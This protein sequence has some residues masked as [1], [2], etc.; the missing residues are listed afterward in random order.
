MKFVPYKDL[1]FETKLTPEQFRHKLAQYVGDKDKTF[2]TDSSDN[3]YN[4]EILDNKFKIIYTLHPSV[5]EGELLPL[6][7]GSLVKMRIRLT[8]MANTVGLTFTYV[9]FAFALVV[10]FGSFINSLRCGK[11]FSPRL[12]G[13]LLL[14]SPSV[15]FY[16]ITMANLER[17]RDWNLK[18]FNK[19]LRE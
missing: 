19:N 10:A 18:F 7:S 5:V 17:A 15:L 14:F 4:G 8:P 13:L 16:L 9:L 12:T 6:E 2:W 3:D 11:P 1:I